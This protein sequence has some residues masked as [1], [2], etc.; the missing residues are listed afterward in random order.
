MIMWVLGPESWGWKDQR[1]PSK[2]SS[3]H[4]Y[5]C[6][7]VILITNDSILLIYKSSKD[8]NT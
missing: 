3:V 6:Q 5:P 1:S 4:Q 7:V 8:K 2:P